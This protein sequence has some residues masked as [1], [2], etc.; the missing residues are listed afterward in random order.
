MPR[1]NETPMRGFVCPD[2]LWARVKRQAHREEVTAS[3]LIR[4]VLEDYLKNNEG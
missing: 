3:E 1:P 4:R 2:S